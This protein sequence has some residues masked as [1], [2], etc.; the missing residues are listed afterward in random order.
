MTMLEISKWLPKP[1]DVRAPKRT[2]HDAERIKLAVAAKMMECHPSQRE[3]PTLAMRPIKDDSALAKVWQYALLDIV[4]PNRTIRIHKQ[5]V[6]PANAP[7]R[8]D[9][10][11]QTNA[12]ED[13]EHDCQ[14]HN[15]DKQW[16][17]QNQNGGVP[18][19]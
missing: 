9:N 15:D 3:T 2:K 10:N 12:R 18:P 5:D 14:W 19:L 7:P 11:A 13:E 4:M 17:Q 16:R 8:P 6:P 1:E